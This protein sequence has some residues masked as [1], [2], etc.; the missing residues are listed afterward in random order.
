MPKLDEAV[1]RKIE[2]RIA[3]HDAI[4]QS[5]KGHQW[6]SYSCYL[7]NW[8]SNGRTFDEAYALDKEHIHK[9]H[10]VEDAQMRVHQVPM[11]EI[12]ASLH[13]HDCTEVYCSCICGCTEGPFCGLLFGSMCSVCVVRDGRG[14]KEHGPK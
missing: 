12:I 13:D 2:E 6:M 1:R 4:R 5:F 7:C 3:M 9:E 14:D 10:P 8:A 11:G